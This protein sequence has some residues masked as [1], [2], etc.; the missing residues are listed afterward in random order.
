MKC[1][2]L[3]QVREKLN[4]M[5]RE[6]TLTSGTLNIVDDFGI[7]QMTNELFG[8]SYC[9]RTAHNSALTSIRSPPSPSLTA[10]YSWTSISEARRIDGPRLTTRRRQI[11]TLPTRSVAYFGVRCLPTSRTNSQTSPVLAP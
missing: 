6:K 1:Q 9:A 5:L 4:A 2:V 11:A 10:T 8:C 3:K 7:K